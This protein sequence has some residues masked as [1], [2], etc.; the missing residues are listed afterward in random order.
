VALNT[1]FD[2]RILRVSSGSAGI[3]R[4]QIMQDGKLE[5]VFC[6]HCGKDGGAVTV[7]PP[8]IRG[9]PGVIYVCNECDGTFGELPT[10][11]TSLIRYHE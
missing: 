10:H 2:S 9:D 6:L 5:R 7:I 3:T 1:E 4:P 11:A 8:A